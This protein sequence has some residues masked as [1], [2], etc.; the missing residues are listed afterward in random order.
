[1]SVSRLDARFKDG[2]LYVF[3]PQDVQLIRAWPDLGAVRKPEGEAR[4]RPF[5]PDYPLIRPYRAR[6]RPRPAATGQLELA[7]PVPDGVGGESGPRRPPPSPAERRRRAFHGF[8]FACPKPAA[9]RVEPFRA[10]HLALLGLLRVLGSGGDLLD[11]N[12]GLGFCL[13]VALA[14]GNGPDERRA[15]DLAGRRQ[16][17]MMAALGLP[18]SK[19]ACRALSKVLAP[20]MSRELL[21]RLPRLLADEPA[22]K[23]L[24]HLPSL[25]IGVLS[26]TMDAELRALVTP[27]LLDEVQADPRETHFPFVSRQLGDALQMAEALGVDLTR[28][29]FRSR[30][31]IREVHDDLARDYLRLHDARL[32]AFRFPHPPIPGS[33]D[34]VPLRAPRALIEEGRQQ[35][36]CVATYAEGVAGG[37][38]FVYRVLRPQRATLSL[39]RVSGRWQ[40]GELLRAHNQPASAATW[41]AVERWLDG[42][43]L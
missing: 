15:R 24:G 19:R 6:R 25:G 5:V 13:A 41:R 40:V 21:A 12:P 32:A 36:N 33:G 23:L 1:M 11:V 29:R 34:I 31:R 22:L 17:E 20:S 28:R 14:G 3:T 9:R 37:G 16:P 43:R 35:N 30:A 26:L 7:L 27:A 4:W 10:E 38:I 18:G 2:T 42:Y 8:R 39:E